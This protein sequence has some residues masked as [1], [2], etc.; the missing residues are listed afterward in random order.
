MLNLYISNKTSQLCSMHSHL[1]SANISQWWGWN[2][3]YNKLSFKPDPK[4]KVNDCHIHLFFYSR[5]D[6]TNVFLTRE[7]EQINGKITEYYFASI[8][9]KSFS[10]MVQEQ[11]RDVSFPSAVSRLKT[12]S[13]P[14]ARGRYLWPAAKPETETEILHRACFAHVSLT[15]T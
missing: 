7:R 15:R 1:I 11:L 6:T 2:F 12:I 14:V 13:S 8:W 3:L 9:T 10:G 5:I 4:N